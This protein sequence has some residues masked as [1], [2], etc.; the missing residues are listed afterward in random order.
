M[1]GFNPYKGPP[2]LLDK[3]NHLCRL[4]RQGKKQYEQVAITFDNK[5][6]R[7]TMLTLAQGKQ[8]IRL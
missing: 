7:S 5:D 2:F 6:L 8:S 4:L 3:L 1:I